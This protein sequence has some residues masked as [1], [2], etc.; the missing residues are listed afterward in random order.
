M[1]S[2]ISAWMKLRGFTTAQ[3]AKAIGISYQNLSNTLKGQKPSMATA[4]M[5][6]HA[7][8]RE[9]L[10]AFISF[11]LVNTSDSRVV[12][13]YNRAQQNKRIDLIAA[14]LVLSEVA[15]EE[16]EDDERLL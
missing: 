4:R 14:A 12:E 5:I 6:A 13:F 11:G 3:A 9:P 16:E 1:L 8:G 10:E 7:V 15:D 2:V